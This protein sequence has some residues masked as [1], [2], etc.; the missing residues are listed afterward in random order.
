M[1]FAVPFPAPS[2]SLLTDRIS[3]AD[4]ERQERTAAE[5][6]RRLERQPGL[7]L[8]DEVGMGKTFVA[9][10]TA[11]SVA[12]ARPEDGPV[13]VMVPPSLKQ[14]W[15][16]D[17]EVFRH[18][19]LRGAAASRL[20]AGSADRGVSFLRLLDDPP[21]RRKAIIFLTH[22]A[23]N[24]SLT[25]EWVK[26]ALLR[27]ALLRRSTMDDIRHALPKFAGRLLYS[28]WIDKRAPGVWERLLD[29]PPDR[30][31]RILRSAGLNEVAEDDPVPAVLVTAMD[32]LDLEAV[33]DALRD[34][35]LR[36]SKH[37]EEHLR[38]VRRSLSDALGALWKTWLRQARF[39]SPLLVFDEAH[40]LK[41]VTRLTSLFVEQESE[42]E[43]EAIARGPLAGVFARMLFLTATPFQL[44]HHE[45]VSVLRRF[46]GIAWDG[47]DAPPGGR[48]RFKATIAALEDTLNETQASSL[49]LDKAW[50]RLQPSHLVDE[51]GK[52]L[53]PDDW[54][55]RLQAHPPVEGLIGDVW[56]RYCQCN[57]RMRLAENL[58]RPWVVRHLKPR[59]LPP[60]PP[61]GALKRRE[62]LLGASITADT[63][64]P[65]DP[66]LE[67]DGEALLPFLLAARAQVALASA[68][69]PGSQKRAVFAEGLASSY[70]AYL[71][72]RQGNGLM[73][74]SDIPDDTVS[75]A[76]NREVGWYLSQLDRVLP[77]QDDATRGRHP[78]AAATIDRALALWWD[79]EK[80]L[81]FCHYRATGRALRRYISHRL[82]GQILDRARTA[83]GVA[84]PDIA[85]DELERLGK[86]F[87]DTEGRLRNEAQSLL[88]SV[89][90][91]YPELAAD[92]EALVDVGLRFVRT[93]SFLVRY[94]PL[95]QPDAASAFS[96]AFDRTDVSGMTLRRRFDDLC[97][98]LAK[99]CVSS[100]RAEYLG[101][102]Q[103]LQTGTFRRESADPEDAT[104]EVRYL[105]NVRLANGEVPN[106]TRRRL[107]LAFNT[108]FFPEI[109]IASSVLA[110]GVDLHLDC[111]FVVHHDLS[112]NPSVLEQRTGRVDRI[113]AKAERARRPIHVYLPF[114]TATQ[115][116]KMFR[117]VRDRERWFSVV[118]GE[119]YELDETTT[120]RLAER[121]PLPEAAAR[122]LAFDL[123]VPSGGIVP[124]P[125]ETEDKQ[126]ALSVAPAFTG[127]AHAGSRLQLQIYVNRRA[128]HL[129][130]AL[131]SA[132]P[133]IGSAIEW[134][135]PVEGDEFR[136]YWDKAALD[137]LGFSSLAP[138][139]NDF[140]PAGGPHWDALARVTT[141][142]GPGVLLVEAKSYPEEAYGPGTRAS[143]A[144]RARIE[145]S[146]RRVKEA[147]GVSADVDWL[148]SLY[149]AANRLAFLWFFQRHQ[150]P[151]WL[152][153]LYFVAD[154][155]TRSTTRS[156]WDTALRKQRQQLYGG[157]RPAILARVLDV[158]LDARAPAEL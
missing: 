111:R 52:P 14:K 156:E 91:G 44:G 24:R 63:P 129:N 88:R 57:E 114:V 110:E 9:L 137:V 134:V 121:I 155:T 67:V 136:E 157:Q 41:N 92:Q 151:A 64:L 139:L 59:M 144:S 126:S 89:V 38:N 102:L 62:L 99:R 11:A 104:D 72:T 140:W 146:L 42:K 127:K 40:H 152:V 2:I 54:W 75:Q 51:H 35:P 66:G 94:F 22:G 53:A 135:S 23:L 158:F 132:D 68:P 98:F 90:A 116:E 12:L 149:Q 122:G 138:A 142:Q 65:G 112:W 76:D 85:R 87:F 145:A 86:Q 8:A 123:S 15:P 61:D 16:K 56:E 93:P 58:L 108:P 1:S 28:R 107:M 97:R 101:A 3:P 117:V 30:W 79:G 143:Q 17:W 70:E 109:L 39:R 77:A 95:S 46:E 115:D 34:L 48:D 6:L 81:I 25:D 113:G 124:M 5:I 120:D 36:E 27:R 78:K 82:E 128:D 43:S 71:E 60:A 21:D 32:G 31:Q 47:P 37:V 130:A 33:L 18:H 73:D 150:V 69:D 96:Q 131:L 154:S 147:L 84:S 80:S 10:A 7:I 45:L 118:M 49:R 103:K 50:G 105:P 83:L 26:L 133:E 119:K 100:E 29:T 153:N 19:C 13:V 148:G 4:A 141:S 20:A 74:D 106:E 125:D 55:T